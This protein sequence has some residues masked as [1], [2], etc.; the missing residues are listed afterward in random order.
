MTTDII[1]QPRKEAYASCPSPD[2]RTIVVT[3]YGGTIE[4]CISHAR[5]TLKLD[6][7]WE[8]KSAVVR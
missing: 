4:E 6:A 1:F 3:F 5:E 8:V 7:R 2:I